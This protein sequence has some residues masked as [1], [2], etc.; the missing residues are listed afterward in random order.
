MKIAF[1]KWCVEYNNAPEFQI[2][3]ELHGN[4]R[5]ELDEALP[6]W[7]YTRLSGCSYCCVSARLLCREKWQ[8][9][10]PS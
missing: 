3:L 5:I 4:A 6:N 1:E 7:G 9:F 8:K 10:S 2:A